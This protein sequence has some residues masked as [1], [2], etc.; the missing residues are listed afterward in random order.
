MYELDST[1]S[2][3]GQ[4]VGYSEHGYIILSPFKIL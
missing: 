3:Y 1:D 4:G 2:G